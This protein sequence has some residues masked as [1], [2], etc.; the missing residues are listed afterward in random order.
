[1]RSGTLVHNAFGTFGT[2]K[3][4]LISL[5]TCDRQRRALDVEHIWTLEDLVRAACDTPTSNKITIGMDKIFK[6][7]NGRLFHLT[8]LG[9][10]LKKDPRIT[11]YGTRPNTMVMFTDDE[12]TTTV[13]AT[14]E[15]D[16]IPPEWYCPLTHEPFGSPVFLAD[17]YTY[18]ERAIRD[19]LARKNTS[20]MTGDDLGPNAW[21]VPNRSMRDWIARLS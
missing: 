10:D 13:R 19:W 15:D 18:E 16:L 21:I 5:A 7:C 20:P 14:E 17:G 2:H 8:V 12:T 3:K 1:M 9:K 11:I 6:V 4:M